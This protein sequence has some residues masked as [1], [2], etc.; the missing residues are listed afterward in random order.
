MFIIDLGENILIYLEVKNFLI[1]ELTVN[2]KSSIS[3]QNT[4]I[5][6]STGQ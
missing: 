3:L 2:P 5:G 6:Q 1:K 4:I